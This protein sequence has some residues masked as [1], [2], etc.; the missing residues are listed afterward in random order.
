MNRLYRS[1]SDKIIAGVCGGI[2]EY[3]KIDSVIVRILAVALALLNGL[4]VLLYIVGVIVM[5]EKESDKDK[6]NKADAKAKV[7]NRDS[8]YLWM[9]GI[10][11]VIGLVFLL[12]NYIAWFSIAKLWPVI[13]IVGGI[14]ILVKKR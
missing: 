8:G 6:T 11:I 14:F 4:G 7:I 9:G 13:L 3:L 2:A 10:L 1:N 5:P 12:Q